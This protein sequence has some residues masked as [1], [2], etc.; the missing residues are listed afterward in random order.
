MQYFV[1]EM[2]IEVRVN[3]G[4]WEVPEY[5]EYRE[6]KHVVRIEGDYVVVEVEV[7]GVGKEG[8]TVK[9][10]NNNKLFIRAEGGDR[11]YLLIKELPASVATEG[12][13]AEYRNGLLIIRLPIK[14]VSIGVE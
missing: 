5:G 14:G 7:P 4:N 8:I 13:R 11:K 1:R 9:L 6:P 3:L 2:N 10:L 12:S